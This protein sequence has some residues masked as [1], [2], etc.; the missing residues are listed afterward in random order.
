MTIW[1]AIQE[2]MA[3]GFLKI[4]HYGGTAKGD[5]NVYAMKE[6]WKTWEPGKVC[7]KSRPNRKIGWQKH[8]RVCKV[9]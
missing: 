1:R 2:I 8:N 6:A 9:V 3:H 7:F 5:Y 4:I